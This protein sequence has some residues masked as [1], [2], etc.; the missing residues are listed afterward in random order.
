MS[1]GLIVG[2]VLVVIAI[3]VVIGYFVWRK[4]AFPVSS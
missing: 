2:I 4:D 3:A 1:A